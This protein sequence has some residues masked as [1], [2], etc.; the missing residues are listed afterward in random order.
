MRKRSQSNIKIGLDMDGVLIDHTGIRI[1]LAK[2]YGFALIPKDTPS[3]ILRTILPDKERWA[4]QNTIYN[5]P[6][7]SLEAPLIKNVE[8][9]LKRLT[10][11]EIP[12]FLISRRKDANLAMRLLEARGIWPRY[13]NPENTHFVI[14]PEDKDTEAIKLGITH[15]VDDET[16]VL[17]AL[18]SVPHKILFD[19]YDAQEEGDYVRA[20]SWEDVMQHFLNQ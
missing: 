6:L 14:T 15:Y 17:K 18:N 11:L 5:D 13:F 10:E 7:V 8:E 9:S 1:K 3:D 12:F 16:K 4:I 20:H 19:P 2:E